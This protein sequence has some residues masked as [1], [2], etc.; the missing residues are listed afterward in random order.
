MSNLAEALNEALD[1]TL[2]DAW[3]EAEAEALSAPE[4][5]TPAFRVTTMEGADWVLRKVAR[6]D[7]E[8][9]EVDDL[10]R[11]EIAKIEGWRD[12][13][14]ARLR[15]QRERLEQ[16]AVAYLRDLMAEDPRK[17]SL[18]LPHGKITSTAG[19]LTFEAAVPDE[20]VIAWA[21]QRGVPAVVRVTK[22]I[23]AGPFS[24]VVRDVMATI[25]VDEPGEG[26]TLTVALPDAEGEPTLNVLVTRKQ[27]SFSVTPT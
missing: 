26:E 16:L 21:E 20:S 5:T 2:D 7:D 14:R 6:V 22:A 17:K 12:Q 25:G 24:D 9:H 3:E 13:E 19:R 1:E 27:R 15:G 8:L 10:A 11:V 23:A 18:K 4:P